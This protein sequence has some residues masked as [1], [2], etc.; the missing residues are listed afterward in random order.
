MLIR[1]LIAATLAV[2]SVAPSVAGDIPYRSKVELKVGQ[3]VILKGVR[4]R[5]CDASRASS[6][7]HISGK[8]PN[9]KIGRLSNGGTGTVDSNS[10][11]KTVPARAIKFTATKKGTQRFTIY[12]DRFKVTVK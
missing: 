5:D 2:S 12:G 11:G 1:T 8:L 3:S 7:S 6:F 10:C 4:A 9:L